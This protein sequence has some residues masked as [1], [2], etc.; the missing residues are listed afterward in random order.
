MKALGT[1]F[2]AA[3]LAVSMVL[4]LDRPTRVH[5]QVGSSRIR[6]RYTIRVASGA[7]YLGIDRLRMGEAAERIG[8]IYAE[9]VERLMVALPVAW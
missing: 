7:V 2:L 8:R 5:A 4:V 9:Q 6:F 3:T 1:A